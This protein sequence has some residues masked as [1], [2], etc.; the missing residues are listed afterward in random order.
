MWVVLWK[1]Q[2]GV[3]EL[4]KGQM[5]VRELQVRVRMQDYNT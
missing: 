2:L 1:G 5:G 4:R 3:R